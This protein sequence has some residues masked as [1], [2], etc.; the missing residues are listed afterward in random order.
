MG[1]SKDLHNE[2]KFTK[3]TDP[4]AIYNSNGVLTGATIDTQGFESLEF[5]II[6]GVIT[7]GT[8]TPSL[9]EGDAS[10]M[11]DAAA[12]AAGDLIGTIAGATFA[13]TDD[14]TTKKIGYR[15]SKRYVRLKITQAGATTGGFFLA[16]AVQGNARNAPVA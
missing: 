16:I 1:C 14:S 7:D 9:E 6:S 15:G 4:A 11:S 12:V 8:L 10:N 5:V 13:I 3:S 2:L